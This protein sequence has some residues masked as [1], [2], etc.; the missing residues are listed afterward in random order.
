MT[1]PVAVVSAPHN[2]TPLREAIDGPLEK[3][4]LLYKESPQQ[5]EHGFVKLPLEPTPEMLK[6]LAAVKVG[7]SAPL[8]AARLRYQAIVS[9]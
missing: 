9:P 3:G 4:T 8:A 6:R 2:I 5:T 7:K 1:E